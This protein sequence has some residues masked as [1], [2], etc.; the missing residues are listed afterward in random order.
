MFRLLIFLIALSTAYANAANII[1]VRNTGEAGD[2]DYEF[3][4]TVDHSSGTDYAYIDAG[5]DSDQADAMYG[6]A[7]SAQAH[8]GTYSMY[9]NATSEHIRF[10]DSDVQYWMPYAAGSA[11]M[12]IY[13][14]ESAVSG[15]NQLLQ[16]DYWSD[17]TN[18]NI[19]AEINADGTID[20]Q[21]VGNGTSVT[22]VTTAT[23]SVQTWQRLRFRWSISE[24]A[25]G[26]QIGD[27][28]WENDSDGDSV[29]AFAGNT[30]VIRIG[31]GA[32]FGTLTDDMYIDD[33]KIFN[34]Y[35]TF[36]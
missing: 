28:S 25:I 18:N 24:N 26:V 21:H 7:E 2:G 23:V 6:T 12:W 9:L 1:Y 35:N 19:Y 31:D 10:S 22:M 34:T 3:F 17:P 33:V 4:Y 13:I 14:D 16:T 30:G 29:T 32:N 36:N 15:Q 5:N 8:S 11:E 27:G 20:F